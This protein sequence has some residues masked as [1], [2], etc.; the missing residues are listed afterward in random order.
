MPDN[1][2]LPKELTDFYGEPI[3]VYA[4]Q[5]AIEDG[6]LVDVTPWAKEVNIEVQTCLTAALWAWVDID[7]Q[8]QTS[9]DTHEDTRG[10]AHD[11]LFL[12]WVTGRKAAQETDFTFSVAFAKQAREI[13]AVIDG[14]GLT[15]GFPED[16]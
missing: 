12:A 8:D 3:Y 7:S 4:R 13:R 15:L 10:R 6:V 5:Q 2:K 16:F 11:V 1:P 14:D 9:L